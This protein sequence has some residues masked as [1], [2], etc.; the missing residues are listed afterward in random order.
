MKSAN[1]WTHSS[2]G[3]LFENTIPG[4]WGKLPTIMNSVPVLRST[5]FR[6]DGAVDY[7]D[8]AYRS[9][10]QNSLKLRQINRGTILLV[11]SGVWLSGSRREV[12]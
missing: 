5:N 11:A 1:V 7:S 2:I 3:E 12:F 9:I 8:V 4:D 10:D 6:N